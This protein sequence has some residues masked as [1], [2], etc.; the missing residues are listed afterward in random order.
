MSISMTSR[1]TGRRNVLAAAMLGGTTAAAGLLTS[2][3]RALA[4]IL[5]PVPTLS[6][7]LDQARDLSRFAGWAKRA[8]LQNE[9]ATTGNTALFVPH[10]ASIQRLSEQQV[11]AIERN[12]ESLTSLVKAHLANYPYQILAGGSSNETAGGSGAT[13][14]SQTGTTIVVSNSGG[15]LPRVNNFAIFVA[16]MRA[17]NGIAHCIDGVLGV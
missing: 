6:Q 4:Q 12:T 11:E 8:G 5:A 17:S 16:N 2:Q 7:I 10:N 3:R 9:F 1:T 13:I 15:A 14:V